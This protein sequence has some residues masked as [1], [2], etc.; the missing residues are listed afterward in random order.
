MKDV[1]QFA[2]DKGLNEHVELIKKGALIAQ[3]PANFENLDALNEEE[4]AALRFEADHKWK[5]PWRLYFTIIVCSIGAA[6]QG[7]DQT[8]YVRNHVGMIARSDCIQVQWSQL[9]LPSRVWHRRRRKPKQSK[10][11]ERLVA[12]RSRECRAI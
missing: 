5:H 6:V 2:E 1:E 8:G 12:G 7:W 3:D 11:T 10:S 9:E 4:R